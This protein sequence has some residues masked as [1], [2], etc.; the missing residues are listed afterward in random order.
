MDVS[1]LRS[2]IRRYPSLCDDEKKKSSHPPDIY[3]RT[4]ATPPRKKRKATEKKEEVW[5]GT[6]LTAEEREAKRR[7]TST[8]SEGAS[9]S[10]ASA[11][12]DAATALGERML[13]RQREMEKTKAEREEKR[14]TG[15]A[16]DVEEFD[17]RFYGQRRDALDAAVAE[18]RVEDAVL[19]YRTMLGELQEALCFLPQWD[20]QRANEVLGECL[21]AI[22]TTKAST[23]KLFRFTREARSVMVTD[24]GLAA[25]GGGGEGTEGTGEAAEEAESSNSAR[26]TDKTNETIHIAPTGSIFLRRLTNCKVLIKPVDGSVFVQDCK[27]CVFVAAARQFRIHDTTSTS[28]Y[29]YCSSEPIIEAC[30]SVGFAPYNWTFEK[31]DDILASTSLRQT[32]NM[33]DKV[34]HPPSC[35][36]HFLS[37]SPFQCTG[38]RLQMA[39]VAAL[40]ELVR[41]PC[42]RTGPLRGRRRCGNKPAACGRVKRTTNG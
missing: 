35:V 4:S 24:G 34:W 19:T 40:A 18:G 33:W 20:K 32:K 23:R 1:F 21:K 14:A 11:P 7:R 26:I 30:S 36:S 5:G 28:F 29:I 3:P 37:P 27:D 8:M 22:N 39:S 31:K 12:V 16:A 42:R 10:A 13:R 41:H 17:A 25:G 38:Q 9:A 2:F 6:L 15:L